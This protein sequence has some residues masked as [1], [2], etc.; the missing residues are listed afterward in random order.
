MVLRDGVLLVAPGFAPA[1]PASADPAS[2]SSIAGMAVFL[3]PGHSGVFDASMARQVTTGRGGTKDC[4]TSGTA[5]ADGFP[6][7]TFNYDVAVEI[8]DA[9]NRLGVRTLLSRADDTSAAPCNDE[10]SAAANAMH[11]DAIVSI[12]AD[13]ATKSGHGFHV[14]YSNPPLNEAQSGRA[15]QLATTMRDS[16]VTSGLQPASYIGSDGLFGRAD[17]TGLNL[18]Q[19]PAVLVECGNMKNNDEAAQMESIDG[20]GRYAA[21]ITRGIVA[22]LSVE[23]Q[24]H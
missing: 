13:G 5:T 20:R 6:E 3:D 14:N 12:H 10:R 8:R 23:A 24:A 17:L 7:H 18:D 4:Q 21:A 2:D 22:Y 15:V 16:L 19:Y 9:L 11:P 1:G